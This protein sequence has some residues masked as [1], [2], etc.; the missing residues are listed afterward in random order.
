MQQVLKVAQARCTVCEQFKSVNFT[1]VKIIYSVT[2]YS[3]T[4]QQDAKMKLEHA[5]ILLVL[6][7]S[8]KAPKYA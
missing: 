5:Y 1:T 2:N 7:F 4:R 3:V 6:P 8:N